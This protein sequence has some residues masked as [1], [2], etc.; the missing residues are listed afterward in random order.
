M[1]VHNIFASTYVND[2]C[3]ALVLPSPSL[4]STTVMLI[5]PS[6]T[7]AASPSADTLRVSLKSSSNSLSSSSMIGMDM[8]REGIGSLSSVGPNEYV[9]VG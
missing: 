7:L 5:G 4:M 3:I 6:V 9:V 8:T 1:V 2:Y